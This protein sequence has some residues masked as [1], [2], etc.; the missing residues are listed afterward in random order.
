MKKIYSFVLLAAALLLSTNAFAQKYVATLG[1][2][3][4]NDT[5]IADAISDWATNGGELQLLN[6]CE[7]SATATTTISKNATLNLDGKTLTWKVT[8]D[9]DAIT[10][11]E[12]SNLIIQGDATNK[13]T[14]SFQFKY[15]APKTAYNRGAIYQKAGNCTIT[16]ATIDCNIETTSTNTT[17]LKAANLYS[18]GGELSFLNT[19]INMR[20]RCAYGV[21]LNENSI[22]TSFE[23]LTIKYVSTENQALSYDPKFYGI[24]SKANMLTLDDKA[25]VQIDLSN[26]PLKY[27]TS[28]KKESTTLYQYALYFDQGQLTLPVVANISAGLYK[29][30]ATLTNSFAVSYKGKNNPSNSNS[31]VYCRVNIDGG[32]FVG[33]KAVST[34]YSKSSSSD[35]DSY[36]TG[37]KFSVAPKE[38]SIKEG[39]EAVE[40]TTEGA[41]KGYYEVK[42]KAVE[43]VMSIDGQTYSTETEGWTK[44]STSASSYTS[45]TLLKDVDYTI[46]A[47]I[48]VSIE[49]EDALSV[50]SITNNGNLKIAKGSWNNTFDNK[51][52]FSIEG[53]SFGDNF[54]L[55]NTGTVAVT[56]GTFTAKAKEQIKDDIAAGYEALAQTDGT[57]R[58]VNS[59]N[60]IAE[61]NGIKYTD[62]ENA[63]KASS[64]NH[65]AILLKDYTKTSQ[66][67]P[68]VET[69]QAMVLNMN[70]K[71]LTLNKEGADGIFV[72][73]NVDLTIQGEGTI[74]SNAAVV[75][76]VRGTAND[77]SINYSSLTIG[78]KVVIEHTYA[79]G[80]G[81]AVNDANRWYGVVVNFNGVYKGSNAFYINGTYTGES[82]NMPT[83][84]IG[85]TANITAKSVAYAGGY[86]IWNYAGEATTS[87]HGFEIRAGK[88]TMN[89]G[90]IVCTATKPADDQFNGNGSTSQACG[91]AVCQHSTNLPIN[92]VVNGGY[93]KA[94]TPLYQANPNSTANIEQINLTVKDGQFYS[95]SKNIVYSLNK[96]IFLEGGVYNMNPAAYVAEGKAVVENTNET[97][98]TTYPYAIGPKADAVTTIKEGNW[99][100]AD[101]WKDGKVP[102][103]ATPV[104]IAHNVIVP[105]NVKAEAFGIKVENGSIITV[106]GSLVIGNEGI[107]GI[108]NANQLLIQDGGAMV[109]SP[110]AAKEN[111]QP[112]ATV[113]KTLNIRHKAESEYIEGEESPYVREHI[114]IPTLED[115]KKSMPLAYRQ[116]NTVSGW[117]NATEYGTPFK[118][119]SVTNETKP[120]GPISFA[121][122]LVGNQNAILNMPRQGFHFVANSW[123]APINTIEVLNQVGK[124]SNNDAAEVALKI[125][126][127]EIT[128]NGT[129]H[130][131]IFKDINK[132]TLED[133]EETWGKIAPM[134]A[135]FLFANEPAT[136]TLSY[137]QAAWNTLLAARFAAPKRIMEEEENVKVRIRLTAKDGHEDNVTLK[138]GEPFHSTKMMNEKPN[139]NIY[140]DAEAGN[141][142]TFVT[143]D[144]EGTTLKIQT[145]DQTEYTLSF[146]R[147][148]GETL[149]IK[150]LETG[151]ITAMTAEN[152]YTFKA[153]ANSTIRRFVITRKEVPSSVEDITISGVKGVYTIMGQFLGENVD[154]NTLPQGIYVIDGQ[155]Y[156]K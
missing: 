151:A 49:K 75:F 91:I 126:I 37:G 74:N 115:P 53:G 26:A 47:G 107:D 141:Y 23:G 85:A 137:E 27:L 89:G 2:K 138:E 96:R 16:N 81:V 25:N 95:T 80:Y 150:D 13:G 46:P 72:I 127:P 82:N 117:E 103:G 122:K 93:I 149:A 32:V 36:I 147:L 140:V 128:I 153:T 70:G 132:V 45:V 148:K 17:I 83:F 97:T 102:T 3:T 133:E 109:I 24:W 155:K 43:P 64:A 63:L 22:K 118:G 55:T 76:K 125:Y 69:R 38:A 78:E 154:L 65:P 98:K 108:T 30:N 92:V 8:N 34:Y 146:D 88:L 112:F 90:S 120:E 1:S 9:V 73:D 111:S 104:V 84:N 121:G 67:N 62:L 42:A 131:G 52:T 101:T 142:S 145:N 106:A 18:V 44:C 100:V 12:G 87:H 129:P 10:I 119:Y 124:L 14:L 57:Y 71:T 11:A 56:G 77:N 4:Y 68:N 113:F 105:A 135:F 31:S 7:Y 5:Q 114:G 58:I 156:I 20:G 40:I 29:T 143:E 152:T 136:I 139:V 94:Y 15:A 144:L 123:V 79:D 35:N 19:T 28:T 99:D 86:G 50:S 116:W 61:V 48:Y 21:Y 39:Y 60:I 41:Y 54:V 33:A 110:A 59:A 66:I 134:Q 6:D 130:Y 51:G